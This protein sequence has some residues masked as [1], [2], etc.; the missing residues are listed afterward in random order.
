MF[1]RY[2]SALRT[3]GPSESRITLA[4]G[5]QTFTTSLHVTSSAIVKLG[6]LVKAEKVYRGVAGRRLP[7]QLVEANEWN[8]R[9]GIEVI[10]S[11]MLFVG[12]F[13]M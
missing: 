2:N 12:C 6:K 13:T 11:G 1:M 9:G 8:V 10:R 5:P 3:A 7:Q 4:D